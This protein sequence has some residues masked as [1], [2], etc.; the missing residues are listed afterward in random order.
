VRLICWNV[1]G[2]A[3]LVAAQVRAVSDR[4]P[5]IV[6]VQELR[7][8]TVEAWR[9]ALASRGFSHFQTTARLVAERRNFVGVASR[10]PLAATGAQ[11]GVPLPELVLSLV[12]GAPRG[13]LE[14]ITTHV[15]NAQGW[16][17]RK[18]EHLEALYS[19][20]GH[21]PASRPRVLCGDFN[22]PRREF[23]D[24]TVFTWAHH[25]DGRMRPVRGVRWDAAERSVI[26]G[27]AAFG[28]VDAYRH[29]NGFTPDGTWRPGGR[30]R[31]RR[32][33]H[34]FAS[35]ELNPTRCSFIHEWRVG[36]G[37]LSDHSAIEVDFGRRT[38]TPRPDCAR[39]DRQAPGTVAT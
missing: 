10:W 23:E 22:A 29:C 4:A 36:P 32:F 5:D 38:R 25:E 34:V 24:G 7:A 14:L 39:A 28:M 20:L 27:L 35:R 8:G 6:A 26:L 16:G 19:Y 30:G 12:V 17:F 13:E 15:P 3:R 11:I 9:A 2:R 37:R 31:E 1:N 18:V 21:A 33:D